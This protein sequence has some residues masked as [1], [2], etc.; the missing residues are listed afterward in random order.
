MEVRRR[1]LVRGG[2]HTPCCSLLSKSEREHIV[3][4]CSLVVEAANRDRG[5]KRPPRRPQAQSQMS[6]AT[7]SLK[8]SH[9]DRFKARKASWAQSNVGLR[10]RSGEA[11]KASRLEVSALSQHFSSAKPLTLQ[12]SCDRPLLTCVSA[13][14]TKSERSKG[15]AHGCSRVGGLV[16]MVPPHFVFASTLH[17]HPRIW[18]VAAAVSASRES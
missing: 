17:F 1:G 6:L 9:V 4:L 2:R 15:R 8:R 3:D 12:A 11:R 10:A 16:G 18:I 14:A 5:R 7:P 13:Q